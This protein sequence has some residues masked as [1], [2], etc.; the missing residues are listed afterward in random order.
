MIQTLNGGIV[1]EEVQRFQCDHPLFG[2][3]VIRR[4]IGSETRRTFEE[5]IE[6]MGVS[7]QTVMEIGSREA[8]LATIAQGTGIG[9]ASDEEFIGHPSLEK[10][11]ISNVDIRMSVHVVCLAERKE[12]PIIQSFLEVVDEIVARSGEA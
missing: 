11:Q 9:V 7:V 6:H 4:E 3:K 12:G 1:A 5:A 8:M 10:I 2:E